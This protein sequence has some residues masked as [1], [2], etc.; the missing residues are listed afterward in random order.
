MKHVIKLETLS[1][2][3]VNASG[4]LSEVEFQPSEIKDIIVNVLPFMKESFQAIKEVMAESQEH[5]RSWR[6]E[7]DQ[8]RRDYEDK[9]E[10]SRLEEAQRQRDHEEKLLKMRLDANFIG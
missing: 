9:H 4:F 7:E 6:V 2:G 1:A 5:T 8:R 3:P 10:Q